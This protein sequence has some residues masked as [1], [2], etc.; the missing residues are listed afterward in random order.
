MG[1]STHRAPDPRRQKVVSIVVAGAV[2]LA[3]VLGGTAIANVGATSA[4]VTR[5]VY[6]LPEP[7]PPHV[8]SPEEP[9]LEQQHPRPEPEQTQPEQPPDQTRP[10]QPAQ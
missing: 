10:D 2:P 9:L 8:P 4:T 1:T 6:A 3:L 5:S 7:P